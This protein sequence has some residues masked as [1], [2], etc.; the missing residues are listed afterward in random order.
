MVF[1]N[2]TAVKTI[3]Q[4]ID[5]RI[6]QGNTQLKGAELAERMRQSVANLNKVN[7]LEILRLAGIVTNEGDLSK[8]YK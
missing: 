2:E 5:M 7:C 4:I 1:L 6:N 8:H 3:I